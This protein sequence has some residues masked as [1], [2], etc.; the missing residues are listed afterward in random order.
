VCAQQPVSIEL[1]VRNHRFEPAELRA[2]ANR[3]LVLNIRNHDAAAIEF[4]SVGLRVRRRLPRTARE[5]STCVRCSLAAT[6]SSTIFHPETRGVLV[7]Q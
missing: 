6:P 2:P 5:L 7:A 3:P 1:A 4:E